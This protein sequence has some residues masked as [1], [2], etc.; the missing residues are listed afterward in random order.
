MASKLLKSTK[1][2]EAVVV[3]TQC[4][5]ICEDKLYAYTPRVGIVRVYEC[6]LHP[7]TGGPP[8]N[9]LKPRIASTNP[10]RISGRSLRLGSNPFATPTCGD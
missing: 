9:K 2:D 10:A 3:A 4:V 5:P 1:N 8:L 6:P 7:A